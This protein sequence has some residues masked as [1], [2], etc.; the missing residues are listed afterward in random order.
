MTALVK[1]AINAPGATLTHDDNPRPPPLG[2]AAICN[3][4]HATHISCAYFATS[5][6]E[7]NL[8]VCGFGDGASV[9]NHCEGTTVPDTAVASTVTS[10]HGGSGIIVVCEGSSGS[11]YCELDERG[12]GEL[13]HKG[14][15]GSGIDTGN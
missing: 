7:N 8:R 4:S 5:I 3:G 6:Y 14:T 2:T 11:I 15:S 9:A 12:H 10:K 13:C 1:L